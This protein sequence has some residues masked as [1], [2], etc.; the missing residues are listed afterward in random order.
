MAYVP[1][2]PFAPPPPVVRTGEAPEPEGMSTTTKAVLIA[3][4]VAGLFWV[5]SRTWEANTEEQRLAAKLDELE[6]ENPDNRPQQP[7]GH[8]GVVIV[9]PPAVHHHG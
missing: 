9:M 3:V 1:A 6:K 8:S 5:L 2:N 4:G 7:G